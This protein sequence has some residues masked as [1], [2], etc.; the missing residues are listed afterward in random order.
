MLEVVYVIKSQDSGIFKSKE[1]H[2]L[3]EHASS[4]QFSSKNTPLRR[5][6]A[7]V[8]VPM[9][10]KR[11]ES[12]CGLGIDLVQAGVKIVS[13]KTTEFILEVEKKMNRCLRERE[14][15]RTRERERAS[16]KGMLEKDRERVCVEERQ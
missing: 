1:T 16:A 12:V 2:H 8:Y 7:L 5:N 15:E 11:R 9:Q 6:D 13:N 14:R 10:Q 4:L 3:S